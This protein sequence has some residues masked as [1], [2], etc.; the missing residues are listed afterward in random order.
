[1]DQG[2]VDMTRREERWKE[3][4][5]TEGKEEKKE[6]WRGG[7]EGPEG[8]KGE[9]GGRTFWQTLPN[10]RNG[11]PFLSLR[12]VHFLYEFSARNGG[13]DSVS[14][15]GHVLLSPREVSEYEKIRFC[16]T[17]YDTLYLFHCSYLDRP[18]QRPK[19]SEKRNSERC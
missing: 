6:R 14:P 1:M 7:G 17:I 11:T 8:G 4:E 3:K 16:A 15:A 13:G 19:P 12:F 5:A 18:S 10:R 2:S 9:A